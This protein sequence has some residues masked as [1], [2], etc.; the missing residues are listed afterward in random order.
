LFQ[1][2][3][4]KPFKMLDYKNIK[5]GWSYN[6]VDY[7][8]TGEWAWSETPTPG[9]VNVFKTINHQPEAE[10]SFKSPTLVGIP[11]IFD[12]SD[13][14]DQDDDKLKYAWDFGDGFKNNLAN[15]EHTYLKIG[16]Y[17]VK[18]EV[19]DGQA[20][21]TREKNIK[22]VNSF[23]EITNAGEIAALSEAVRN[24]S[25][26]INEVFP[27]PPGADTE[28]EWLEIKSKS[29][30]E[31]NLLNWRLENSNGKYKFDNAQ[32]L[33]AGAFYVLDNV[34]SRLALKNTDD[35]LSL[36]NNLDELV[37]QVEYVGAV[38]GETYARGANNNW[39]WTT[40]LTPGEENI[41]SL[42]ESK[43]EIV[44]RAS[45][46]AGGADSYIETTLEKIKELDPGSLV[47]VKGTVAVEPGILGVQI[48]YIVGS[49][50]MQIY[51]YKKD[52][53][54]LRVGD[55]VEVAGELAQTQGEFRIKTK[56][57]SSI[58]LIGHKALPVALAVKGDE[59]SEENI[60]QL[61]TITGEITD[62]KSASLY[63]DDGSGE[64]FIYIKQNT[65]ID[66]KSLAAGQKVSITGILS[67]TQT[68][69]RLLPRFQSDIAIVEAGGGLEPQVLGETVQAQE[70]DLA[71]RDKKLE[72]FRYLLIIA[73]G[74]IIV[75]AGLFIK[76]K[77]KI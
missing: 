23:S 42:T 53:P 46:A 35:V 18:L 19:S 33:E 43:S 36:Y 72:L 11:V 34:K 27:N 69:L 63:V 38:Q 26:I 77:K 16:V 7:K 15:P 4:D 41:I 10:F 57:K 58:S 17:K 22:A 55:Y 59:I 73:G 70:W 12:S 25:L 71:E 1:P 51:N 21:G 45:N 75:L 40:R 8:I 68:G 64:I 74:V 65:G 5:E 9:A 44:T 60:G 28:K 54:A 50:G 67:K 14:Y 13:T 30:F 2:L 29:E 66:I 6:S 48:F 3:A 49:P 20:T 62:K 39:F 56:D 32:T 61:I 76:A 31:I 37:D 24:G 52:F 47:I